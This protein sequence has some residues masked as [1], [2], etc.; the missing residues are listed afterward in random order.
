MALVLLGKDQEAEE[1]FRR[2]RLLAPDKA[3]ARLQRVLSIRQAGQ[4]QRKGK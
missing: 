1:D 2:Y 4:Q 3:D